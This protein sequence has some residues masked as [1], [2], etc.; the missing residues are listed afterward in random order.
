[1][2]DIHT[3]ILPGLDDG[4]ASLEESLQMAGIAVAGGISA[5]VATPHVI[6][7][8]YDNTRQRIKEA[9]DLLNRYLVEED[10]PLPVLPGAEY[11]LEPALPRLLDEG[12]LVTINDTGRYLLIE[13]PSDL[14]P[15]YTEQLLYEIQLRGVTPILAHPERNPGLSRDPGRLSRL[16]QRG[17]L[18]QVT[19]GSIQGRFGQIARRTALKMLDTGVAQVVASDAHSTRRRSPAL[20]AAAREVEARWGAAFARTV[21]STHPHRIITGEPVEPVLREQEP[22]FLAQVFRSLSR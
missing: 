3:H 11:R 5:V 19:A 17:V 7:G 13:L 20:T 21:L 8:L 9:V 16:A 1:M 18:A 22:G 4:A 12:R 15:D 10:I 2:I 6:S 14:V